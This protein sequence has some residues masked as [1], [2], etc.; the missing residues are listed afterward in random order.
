LPKENAAHH[1]TRQLSINAVIHYERSGRGE[2]LPLPGLARLHDELPPR[3][4]RLTLPGCGHVPTHD[5]PSLV[6]RA[7]LNGTHLN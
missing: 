4:R 1:V 5:D 6:A 2:P 7:I 3:T